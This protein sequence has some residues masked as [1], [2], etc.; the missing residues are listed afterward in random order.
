MKNEIL[1]I[2]FC[3]SFFTHA[4]RDPKK[5]Y[6]SFPGF[7]DGDNKNP[8]QLKFYSNKDFSSTVVLELD[9]KG[10]V[11]RGKRI[12]HWE[13]PTKEDTEY[14]KEL[15]KL[16]K[17][18]TEK[19]ECSDFEPIFF[20]ENDGIKIQIEKSNEDYYETTFENKKIY[21]RKK[22]TSKFKFEESSVKIE[23]RKKEAA[24]LEL[25]PGKEFFKKNILVDS[26]FKKFIS[27]KNKCIEKKDI[28]C[29]FPGLKK[30]VDPIDQWV[31]HVCRY[32]SSFDLSSDEEEFCTLVLKKS[33]EHNSSEAVS[34]FETYA[35]RD[36]LYYSMSQGFWLFIEEC[37][38]NSVEKIDGYVAFS[39]GKIFTKDQAT[40]YVHKNIG[41]RCVIQRSMEDGTKHL[42]WSIQ[43]VIAN[44]I[45]EPTDFPHSTVLFK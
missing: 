36:K 33:D 42:V 22:E 32:K 23:E 29:L 45:V 38:P 10:L 24:E 26:E 11:L 7:N 5:D 44:D 9:L 13:W 2:L 34:K 39:K 43:L 20:I 17:E 27:Q 12:C 18:Y 4:A 35:N 37:F 40:V 30:D 15:R 3:L 28:N 41:G 19:E 31:K 21:I 16:I 14:V 6:L 8:P 1:L 25:K